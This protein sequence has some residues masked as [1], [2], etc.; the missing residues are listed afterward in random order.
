MNTPKVRK[1]IEDLTGS[2]V[3]LGFGGEEAAAGF[4]VLFR[5]TG[6]LDASQKLLA[7]SADLARVKN[8]SLADASS[9]VAKAN[10]G[11]AKAFKEMGIE[12]DTSL[13]KAQM[14]EK[15]MSELSAKI[16]GQ[17][18]AY[19][20][21]FAGQLAVTKEKFADVAETLGTTLMPY[22]KGFLDLI[23]QTVDWVKKNSSWLSILAGVILTVT[24][25]LAAYSA[26]VKVTTAVTKAWAFISGVAKTVMTG[27]T[28]GQ[29][30]RAKARLRFK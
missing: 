8:I 10:Q 7:T 12:L 20:K 29:W 16:G 15:G 14:L 3:D 1:E 19:T 26:T 28:T 9:I 22:L 21:T 18:T 23:T 2:Y 6:D 5:S 13:P 30:V 4:D 25:A 27:L 11:S 17:A 24:V